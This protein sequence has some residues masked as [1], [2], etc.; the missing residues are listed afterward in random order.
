MKMKITSALLVGC[1]LSE[2]VSF[3]AP[4]G[5]E[6]IAP[7]RVAVIGVSSGPQGNGLNGW[8]AARQVRGYLQKKGD[9]LIVIKGSEIEDLIQREPGL[10]GWEGTSLSSILKKAKDDYYRFKFE[11]SLKGLSPLLN[12]SSSLRYAGQEGLEEA[13]LIAGLN[14]LAL[15]DEKEAHQSFREAARLKPTLELD[16]AQYSPKV[17]RAFQRAREEVLQNKGTPKVETASVKGDSSITAP[18]LVNLMETEAVEEVGRRFVRRLKAHRVLFVQ[19]Q[20]DEAR[21]KVYARHFDARTGEVGGLSAVEVEQPARFRHKMASLLNT[22]LSLEGPV[23]A[24]RSYHHKDSPGKDKKD[25]S[26]KSLFKRPLFWVIGSLLVA[27]AGAG[28]GLGMSG[29]GTPAGDQGPVTGVAVD[30]PSPG[31]L[32]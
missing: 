3:A 19:S 21:W 11:E 32:R 30:V 10:M 29:L 31:G 8:E 5:G 22:F 6:K 24:A 20:G 15:S 1:L 4:Q 16:P 26:K 14:H 2:S 23:V 9:D 17:F 13:Y 7:T 25:S 12:P 18:P 28:I 27:G